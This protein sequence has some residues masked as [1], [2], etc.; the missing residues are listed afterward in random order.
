MGLDVKQDS[1]YFGVVYF[2][3]TGNIRGN[4]SQ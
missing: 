1:V 3:L 2:V 4:K